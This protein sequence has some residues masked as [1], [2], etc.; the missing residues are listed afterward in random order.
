MWLIDADN[1]CSTTDVVIGAP[2]EDDDR[3]AI[4]VYCGRKDFEETK[5]YCQKILA[6]TIHT[7]LRGFGYSLAGD[8]D[9]NDDGHPGNQND[10]L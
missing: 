2:F 4:Y 9:F 10:K 1:N 3:G 5:T 8:R 7:N 6:A